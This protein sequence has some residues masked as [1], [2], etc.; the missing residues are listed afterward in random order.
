M[1]PNGLFSLTKRDDE[2]VAFYDHMNWGS[3]GGFFGGYKRALK[4]NGIFGMK[5]RALKPNGLS[6]VANK[7]QHGTE[8]ELDD[9]YSN[10]DV[11]IDCDEDSEEDLDKE[12]TET[13]IF[14]QPKVK[15]MPTSGLTANEYRNL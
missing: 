10:G 8:Y 5:K 9:D 1:K 13:Q 15:E 7:D 2:E 6:Y 14:G 4:P 3:P 11:S 12:R